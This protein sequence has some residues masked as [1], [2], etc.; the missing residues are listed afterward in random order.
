MIVNALKHGKTIE[1][2]TAA[3][4]FS[5]M[6]EKG[7]DAW[8]NALMRLADEICTLKQVDF[9]TPSSH[10]DV[11]ARPF[12]MDSLKLFCRAVENTCI[13]ITEVI[14]ILHPDVFVENGE[15]NK[16]KSFPTCCSAERDISVR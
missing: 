16:M 2:I 12:L 3:Y 9:V 10:C 1:D 5:E 11:F 14:G 8:S 13:K 15:L 6:S 7:Q 4:C